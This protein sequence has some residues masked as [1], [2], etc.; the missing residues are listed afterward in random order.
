[1][2]G[3]VVG[4]D[5]SPSSCTALRWALEEAERHSWPVTAVLAWGFLDQHHADAEKPFDP[6]YTAAD[7]AA[8][9]EAYV[10]Q[11][12][13]PERVGRVNRVAVCDLAAPALID[14]AAG[15]SLLVVGARGVGGFKGL[16]LGSV[17]QHCLHHARSPIAI[18]RTPASRG[19][20]ATMEQI[21]VGVDGSQP[22]R[23]ALRWAAEEARVRHASLQ[24]VMS[25][26]V[27]Y[28]GS[29]PYVGTAFDPALFERDARQTLDE[30][31]DATATAGVPNVERVLVMGDAASALLTASK[32]ADL[33]VVGSRG[34]G[35]FAGLLLGSVSHHL[36]HHATC[37]LVIIPPR[38]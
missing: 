18:V 22:S 23:E 10:E 29:Y 15:A 37:P 2:K 34:L 38:T 1:M 19:S 4:I 3:L 17:S 7:A 16:L 27:P 25:W 28:V 14:E 31:V 11:A 35:G 20:E 32:D 9:L 6:S 36:A 30:L 21:I 24:V 33:L 5:G 13:G 8:A 26:H 12:V